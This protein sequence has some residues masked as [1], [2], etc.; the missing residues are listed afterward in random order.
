MLYQRTYDGGQIEGRPSPQHHCG[1]E[2]E[3]VG[4]EPCLLCCFCRCHQLRT[5]V[6]NVINEGRHK[7][8]EEGE[9]EKGKN[10][11]DKTSKG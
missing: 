8:E 7:E 5:G 11:E 10:K 3:R 6:S 9:E 2:G 4:A 1:L